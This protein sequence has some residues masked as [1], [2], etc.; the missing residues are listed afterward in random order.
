MMDA[1]RHIETAYLRIPATAPELRAFLSRAEADLAD[2]GRLAAWPAFRAD[3]E[4]AVRLARAAL[5]DFDAATKGG[6]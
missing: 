6:E 1:A 3:V 5:A 2:A 4:R